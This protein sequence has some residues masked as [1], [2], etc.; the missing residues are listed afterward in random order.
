MQFR[1]STGIT[2]KLRSVVIYYKN[3]DDV[4][5]IISNHMTHSRRK[6]LAR[7]KLFTPIVDHVII[8]VM[9]VVDSTKIS[10]IFI[11]YVNT[12]KILA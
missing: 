8:L 10:N 11:I 2:P 6:I 3:D 4:V 5:E 9:V 12:R 1:D 7:F